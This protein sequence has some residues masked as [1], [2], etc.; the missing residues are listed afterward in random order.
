[1][2]KNWSQVKKAFIS[3][4]LPASC[5]WINSPSAALPQQHRHI[6]QASLYSQDLFP[7]PGDVLSASVELGVGVG[8]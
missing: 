5:L 3:V 2:E 4:I 7:P 1:M 6:K 8:V